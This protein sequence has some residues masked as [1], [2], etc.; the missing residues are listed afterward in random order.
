MLKEFVKKII[1]TIPIPLTKNHK[2]DLLSRKIIKKLPVS[3]NCIDVGAYKGEIL[4]LFMK[5]A[6]HGQHF[7]IEPLPAHFDFLQRKFSK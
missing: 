5:V 6:P 7:G 4:D 2:Y 3:A 1:K